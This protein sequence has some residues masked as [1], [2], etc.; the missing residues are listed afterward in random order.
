MSPIHWLYFF[1]SFNNYPLTSRS[2]FLREKL[3]FSGMTSDNSLKALKCCFT[4]VWAAHPA[5]FFLT[6][7][8]A[9]VQ[10]ISQ[11]YTICGLLTLQHLPVSPHL[12]P[13]AE[14]F[15][16]AR[17]AALNL[18]WGGRVEGAVP[19]RKL[20]E[21]SPV[22]WAH[23]FRPSSPPLPFL[24]SLT[25]VTDDKASFPAKPINK[26]NRQKMSI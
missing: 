17:K 6:C 4:E 10:E 5:S 22:S 12:G 7:H 23:Q 24:F 25:L 14:S 15:L 2:T 20:G 11:V 9:I 21:A 13:S 1:F 3:D 16:V 26:L 18:G 19:S 8:P